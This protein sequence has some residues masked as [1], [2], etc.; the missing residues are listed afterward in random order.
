MKYIPTFEQY[1]NEKYDLNESYYDLKTFFGL[2]VAAEDL[3]GD[4]DVRGGKKKFS[5]VDADG[6]R[7]I[8]KVFGK[9][10]YIDDVK[11]S[12]EEFKNLLT[13]DNPGD[14]DELNE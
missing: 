9:Y 3:Y 14:L 11:Y 7:I 12:I 8:V 6:E 2:A 10:A 13:N 4:M 5:Y 1:I